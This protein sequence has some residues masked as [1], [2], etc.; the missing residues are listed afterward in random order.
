[1]DSSELVHGVL[2]LEEI[3][4][5]GYHSWFCWSFAEEVC[6]NFNG[7]GILLKIWSLNVTLHVSDLDQ[8]PKFH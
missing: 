2:G 3:R 4:K 7:H 8:V 5:G 6:S 1:M